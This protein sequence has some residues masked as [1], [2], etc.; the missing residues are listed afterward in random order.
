MSYHLVKTFPVILRHETKYTQQRP[1]EVVEACV[2]VIRVLANHTALVS[3]RTY[4]TNSS[5]SRPTI[6]TT[7]NNNS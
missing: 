7:T 4:A 6:I 2:A 5:A 1:A 3:I